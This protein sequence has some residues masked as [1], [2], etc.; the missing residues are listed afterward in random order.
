[1]ATKSNTP[2]ATHPRARFNLDASAN[3]WTAPLAA[4]PELLTEMGVDPASVM[5]RVG[6]D[7]ASLLDPGSRLPCETVGRLGEECVRATGCSHFGVLAG[8]RAGTAAVGVLAD[9]VRNAESVG[10]GLRLFI[11]HVRLADRGLT[12]GLH[13]LGRKEVELTATLFSHDMHGAAH[14]LDG[15]LAIACAVVR[16]LCGREW[17]PTRVTLA[18]RP[19]AQSS[20]YRACFGA[21][22]QFDAARAALIFPARDLDRPIA[23][24]DI[25]DRKRWSR[26]VADLEA[27]LPS[28]VTESAIR[29]LCEIVVAQPPARS[30]VARAIGLSDRT[31]S[32]RLLEEGTSFR[33]LLEEVRCGLA[34]Q[35]LED[36]NMPVHEIA[37]TLHYSAP[38]AFTRAFKRWSGDTP[39]ARRARLGPA[40]RKCDGESPS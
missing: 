7:P 32:R 39:E 19:P 13:S 18:R 16:S 23:G 35:L 15:S 33:A 17:N 27:D 31:M 14:Y 3:L 1:M 34:C 26:V 36:T 40:G 20:P 38:G 4:I 29:A 22:V 9:L 2:Q 28:S 12:L 5:A 11:A 30:V 24:A 8:A 21:P 6:V 25:A 10:S 37:A